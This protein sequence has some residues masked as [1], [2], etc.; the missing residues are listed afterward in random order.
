MFKRSTEVVVHRIDSLLKKNKNQTVVSEDSSS[1]DEVVPEQDEDHDGLNQ[2]MWN[3]LIDD[4]GLYYLNTPMQYE[5]R[6][7]KTGLRGFRPGPTQTWLY[8]HRKWI[9]TGNFGFRK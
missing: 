7:E 4:K 1:Q 9:E 6:S 5:P 8:S 2:R 3:I